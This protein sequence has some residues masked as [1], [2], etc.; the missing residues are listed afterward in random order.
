MTQ[1]HITKT[2]T[3]LENKITTVTQEIAE[4]SDRI[5]AALKKDSNFFASDKHVELFRRRS[6]LR[7]LRDELHAAFMTISRHF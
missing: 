6:D 3:D 7:N 1:Q 4:I 5:E 2:L